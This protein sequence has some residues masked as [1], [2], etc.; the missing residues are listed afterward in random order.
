MLK[1]T[2]LLENRW[3]SNETPLDFVK[4]NYLSA[5]AKIDLKSI[6]VIQDSPS[7]L[8]LEK[9]TKEVLKKSDV[10]EKFECSACR[11]GKKSPCTLGTKMAVVYPHECPFTE[12]TSEWKAAP[13]TTSSEIAGKMEWMLLG[14]ESV[15]PIQVKEC[16]KEWCKQLR[17]M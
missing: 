3:A 10:V 4:E 13:N 15:L 12:N 1:V 2:M 7:K 5:D 11:W 8:T 17:S 16:I 9:R 6:E 14:E